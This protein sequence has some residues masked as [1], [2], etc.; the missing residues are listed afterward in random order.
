MLG[1]HQDHPKKVH[2]HGE[3]KLGRTSV[4]LINI[5]K[6]AMPK[7]KGL[8]YIKLLGEKFTPD[9]DDGHIVIR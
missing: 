1:Q 8:R 2:V 4:L 9:D 5:D 3:I 6:E 7:Q